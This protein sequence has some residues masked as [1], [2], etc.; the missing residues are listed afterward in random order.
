MSSRTD[1]D[2]E[3]ARRRVSGIAVRT[4]LVPS[5]PLSDAVGLEVFL[6]LETT[7]PTGAFKVRGAASK[8]LALSDEER[9]RGVVT[10][11]TGNHGRAVAYVAGRLGV[12]ATVCVSSGVPPGKIAALR[13]L[14]AD[15]EV[16]GDSQSQ[17]LA[18]AGEIEDERGTALIHPFDDPDVI[19]GQATIGLEII[20]DLPGAATVLAPLSGGGLLAGVASG[21]VAA[22][23]K[24]KA[25]GVSMTRA[26]MMAMSLEAGHPVEVPEEE[27]LADSLRGGIGLHNQFT[28]DLVRELAPRAI[29]VEEAAIW[30][31]MGFLF[32]QHRL[33]VEGAA[34]VGVASL[35]RGS[36]RPQRGPVAVVISG[37]NVEPEHLARL[38]SG[39]PAPTL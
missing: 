25:V 31:A 23:S 14:G 26:P 32:E 8:I 18:R 12:T 38:L 1:I 7:Q 33:V 27:T 35:L 36:V 13:A 28:F 17:A 5:G 21:L 16:V 9:G 30:E 10:A 19:A 11:S 20:E 6:K 15:I 2:V 39:D 3:G 34:A 4:P 22:G 24:A 37:A 29:L